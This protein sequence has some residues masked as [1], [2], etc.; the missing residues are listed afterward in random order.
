VGRIE[1]LVRYYGVGAI[2]TVFGIGLYSVLVFVGVNLFVAQLI[3]HVSGSVF[4]YFTYSR[5]VF[6]G[7]HRRPVAYGISYVANY[8]Y[9]LGILAAIHHFLANPY[10]DIFLAT[11]IGTAV[12]YLVLKRF[13]FKSRHE[14]LLE[15]AE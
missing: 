14:P 10:L 6:V 7:H 9:G 12:N 8:L 15:L 5:H 13:A 11:L 3:A 4:N 2:N 1:E